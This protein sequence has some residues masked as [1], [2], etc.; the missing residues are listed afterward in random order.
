[1]FSCSEQTAP[2]FDIPLELLN[3]FR[4]FDRNADGNIDPYEFIEL[5]KRLNMSFTDDNRMNTVCVHIGFITVHVRCRHSIFTDSVLQCTVTDD[6]IIIV[7]A[8]L[9][10]LLLYF[11]LIE[12]YLNL[13]IMILVR[14]KKV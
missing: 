6:N 1:M 11:R 7:I 3:K 10:W 2:Q 14:E 13:S 4:S 5:A 12:N 9:Q 8:L